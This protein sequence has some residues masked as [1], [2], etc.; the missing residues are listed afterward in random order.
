LILAFFIGDDYMNNDHKVAFKDT[1]TCRKCKLALK[2]Q[3]IEEF[4]QDMKCRK[5]K[6]LK[7]K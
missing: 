5:C 3:I 4:K 1:E 2:Q 6:K 7:K